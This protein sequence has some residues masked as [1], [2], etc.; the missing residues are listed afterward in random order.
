MLISAW[1]R[2]DRLFA[3]LRG[4]VASRVTWLVPLDGDTDSTVE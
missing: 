4:D 2:V 1:L 3:S